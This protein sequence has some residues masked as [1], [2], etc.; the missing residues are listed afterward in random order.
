MSN[1]SE[2][3][4][5]YTGCSEVNVS[6][7]DIRRED[8]LIQW[9]IRSPVPDDINIRN[10]KERRSKYSK[11]LRGMVP[12]AWKLTGVLLIFKNSDGNIKLN[13]QICTLNVNSE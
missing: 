1:I 8:V 2:V 7:Y 10:L 5:S 6:E 3:K 12:K 11:I 4:A 13:Y 9:Q